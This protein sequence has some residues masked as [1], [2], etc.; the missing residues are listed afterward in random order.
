MYNKS[1]DQKGDMAVLGF[2]Y[3]SSWT[4][5]LAFEFDLYYMAVVLAWVA[6]YAS[7]YMHRHAYWS[8]SSKQLPPLFYVSLLLST[9]LLPFTLVGCFA[10][11]EHHKA[12]GEPKVTNDSDDY[13][14]YDVPPETSNRI[15]WHNPRPRQGW[16]ALLCLDAACAGGA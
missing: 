11:W 14:R 9:P 7:Y 13:E 10:A 15:L 3:L 2:A 5:W 16:T 8:G 4:I 12:V 1:L 6:L